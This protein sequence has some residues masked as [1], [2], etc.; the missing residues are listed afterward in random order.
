MIP[1][2]IFTSSQRFRGTLETRHLRVVDALNATTESFVIL[3]DAEMTQLTGSLQHTQPLS[4]VKLSKHAI[5]F[6]VPQEDETDDAVRRQQRLFAYTPKD[7]HPLLVCL[8]NFEVR[9]N[10]HIPRTTSAPQV[11]DVLDLKGGDFVPMT[12]ATL[13]FLVKPSIAFQAGVVIVNKH[14]IQVAGLLPRTDAPL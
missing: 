7:A 5:T 1:V 6:A 12:G 3:H 13:V 8:P 11:R 10:I 2:E 14:Q 4:I 9:G